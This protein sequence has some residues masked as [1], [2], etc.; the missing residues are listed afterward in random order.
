MG[1]CGEK[2]MVIVVSRNVIV[3][4]VRVVVGVF[5]LY[6]GMVVRG[7]VNGDVYISEVVSDGV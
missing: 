3:E 1:C 6:K 5:L 2:M 4:S 7:I